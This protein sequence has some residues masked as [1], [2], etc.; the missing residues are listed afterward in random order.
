MILL[1]VRGCRALADVNL[2]RLLILA[3]ERSEAGPSR[4]GCSHSLP[5]K[6]SRSDELVND[7]LG[8]YLD[9]TRIRG[10]VAAPGGRGFVT[11][12]RRRR[13]PPG[14]PLR[15]LQLVERNP[16]R[17]AAVLFVA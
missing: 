3:A 10:V 1:G 14:K 8:A 15:Y 9:S 4:H 7:T 6:R 16:V 2:L 5:T 11:W 17:A 13:G 12:L